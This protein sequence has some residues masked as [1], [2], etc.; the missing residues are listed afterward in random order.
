MRTR[1]VT[2]PAPGETSGQLDWE[3]W[4]SL[5]EPVW[6]RPDRE[7]PVVLGLALDIREGAAVSP[8]TMSSLK[9]QHHYRRVAPQDPELATVAP[10]PLDVLLAREAARERDELK[11]RVR[12][13]LRRLTSQEEAVIRL[14]FGIGGA[15]LGVQETADR[16]GYCRST[17]WAVER[18]A[19]ARL[20]GS[21]QT[22]A[23]RRLAA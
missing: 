21:E 22:D 1:T 3:H 7:V 18:R 13:L 8:R 14:R 11:L 17:V 23:R 16:L 12:R 5:I 19:L 20:A 9:G 6:R 15:A 2:E 4:E 10:D